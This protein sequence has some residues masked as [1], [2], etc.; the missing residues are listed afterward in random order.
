MNLTISFQG[1]L[2]TGYVNGGSCLFDD[3]K[4]TFSYLCA[5]RPGLGKKCEVKNGK[6]QSY[7]VSVS[8]GNPISS[9]MQFI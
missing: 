9:P 5:P 1:C 6:N 7:V 8:S 2:M 4:Q 3:K